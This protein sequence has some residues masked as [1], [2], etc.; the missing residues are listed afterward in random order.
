[1]HCSQAHRCRLQLKGKEN[2][3]DLLQNEAIYLEESMK[4]TQSV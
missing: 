4:T 1:M 2:G 3:I